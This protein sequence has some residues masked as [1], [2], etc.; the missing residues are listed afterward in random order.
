MG[1]AVLQVVEFAVQ[2]TG[3]CAHALHVAGPNDA[4]VGSTAFAV[5]QAVLVRQLSFEHVAHDLHVAVPVGTET[6]AWGNRVVIDD[7]QV[8]EA[9]RSEEH[10]S[11]LQ[12]R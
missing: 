3:T 5:A 9:L 11:E 12:S 1:A 8:A 4:A 7:A 2:Y 6:V 10:T